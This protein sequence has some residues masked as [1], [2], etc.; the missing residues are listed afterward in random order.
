MVQDRKEPTFSATASGSQNTSRSRANNTLKNP[1][2]SAQAPTTSDSTNRAASR[3]GADTRSQ[4]MIQKQSSSLLWLAFFIALLAAAACGYLF[5][6]FSSAQQIIVQQQSR[7]FELENKLLLS[8]DEATQSL[9]V[10][11]A[12]VKSL[13]KNV[14]LAMS[15]VDKLWATRNANLDKLAEVK[16]EV[17]NSIDATNKQ[18]T[19]AID[20]LSKQLKQSV[21]TVKQSSSE[22][23][24]LTRTLRERVAEQ[25]RA[26]GNIQAALKN[27]SSS[28]AKL[29]AVSQ[30]V[31]QFEQKLITF[32]LRTQGYDEA[33]E[34]FDKFRLITN[35]DLIDLK[36]RAGITP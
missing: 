26:L 13:D 2:A 15:E 24:L 27:N 7:L 34:S 31:A 18:S 29:A 19:A 23:E 16:T 36:K 14:S 33:I 21:V 30:S 9:T 5:W 10:L 17:N 3:P 22:Q 20:T 32:S 11:S 6:Q 12:N 28:A 25:D 8:D 35:R 1:G 4:V